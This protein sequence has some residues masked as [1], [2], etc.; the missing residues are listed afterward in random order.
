MYPIV[1]LFIVDVY[2][3]CLWVNNDLW[4][5]QMALFQTKVLL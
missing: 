2:V 3:H 4:A 1:A 5:I